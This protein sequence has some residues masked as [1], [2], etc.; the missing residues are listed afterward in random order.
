MI[1]NR[2]RLW[3]QEFSIAGVIVALASCSA[4]STPQTELSEI[5]EPGSV[6]GELAVYIADYD[7]GTSETSY[8]LRD[9][10]GN[11]RRLSFRDHPD[12]DPGATVRV[13]GQQAADMLEVTAIKLAPRLEPAN[14]IG[15]TSQ[16]LIGQP[17]RTP[18]VI[19][20]IAVSVNGG[21][22]PTDASISAA[23][24]TGPKSDNAYVAENSYG[25]DALSGKTYGPLQY[26]LASCSNNDTQG[27][28]N[29]LRSMIPAADGCQ[30][31]AW[32]MSNVSSCGWAGLGSVGTSDKPQKD[33]W[34]NGTTGCVA[35]IQE[36]GHNWGGLHSSSITCSGATKATGGINDGL[37]GCTHSEYGDK[38]DTFGGGCRHMNAWQKLY[39]KWWGGEKQGGPAGSCNAVKLNSQGTFTF[40]LYPTEVPCNG[41]QA[42]EVRFPN[43]KTRSWQGSTLTSWYIEYRAPI[44]AFDGNPPMAPQVQA[45]LGIAPVLP[46]DMNPKGSRVYYPNIGSANMALVAGDTFSDPAGGMK[47]SIDSIDM[48]K[49][50][51]TVVLDG[52][53]YPAMTGPTCLDGSNT[54]FQAPGP[55]DCT[56][57]VPPTDGGMIGAGGMGGGGGAG[58]T[59][60]AGGRGAAGAG[61]GGSGGVGAGGQAGVGQG[62]GGS[63]GTGQAGSGVAGA[64]GSGQA[65]GPSSGG[66]AGRGK[67]SDVEGGCACRVATTPSSSR[68]PGA[69][70]A[71]ALGGLLASRRRGRKVD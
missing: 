29:A 56:T 36:V 21:T 24:L 49:A 11:E 32:V 42:L 43:A 23:W 70:V 67:P 52:A 50:V 18:R 19:C 44:G 34:Y 14:G 27:L 38:S 40:N 2:S 71:L 12:I 20:P 60:G 33:T 3:W 48:S 30:H 54:P 16:G 46:T 9:A 41:V 26:T 28:A 37:T 59:A 5:D 57:V 62:G 55:S 17:M 25:K 65:G 4:G 39:Q 45:R 64:G 58:G 31:Y 8:Y 1:S 15:S 51:V 35:A 69:F 13:W 7:D 66:S 53:A 63:A 10:A 61:G 68:S 47:V 6:K 22:P